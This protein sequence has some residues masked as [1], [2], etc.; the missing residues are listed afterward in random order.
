MG[1]DDPVVNE[2]IPAVNETPAENETSTEDEIP[3]ENETIPAENETIPAENETSTN[4]TDII[5]ELPV[6][7]PKIYTNFMEHYRVSLPSQFEINKGDTVVWR[8]RQDPKR[9]LTL[10][11]EDGLWEDKNLVYGRTLV[12]TFNESGTY[13]YSVIGQSRMSG[14]LIVN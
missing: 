7:E 9:L 6:V 8:N 2:T 10:V 3:T 13:N 12:Y 4:E 1:D 14:S 11:S 5:D